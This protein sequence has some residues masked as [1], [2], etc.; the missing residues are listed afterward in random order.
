MR[1]LSVVLKRGRPIRPVVRIFLAASLVC[2]LGAVGVAPAFAAG[3]GSVPVTANF[4]LASNITLSSSANPALIGV[5]VTVTATVALISGNPASATGTVT[6]LDGGVSIGTG[7]LSGTDATWTGQLPE[8][9]HNLTATYGGDTLYTPGV[10]P[11]FVLP[12][13]HASAVVTTAFPGAAGN[14]LTTDGTTVDASVT[15]TSPT[16][17]VDLPSTRFTVSFPG[18]SGL[19]N[20]QMKLEQLLGG[21]WVDVPLGGSPLSGTFGDPAGVDLP[22][23]GTVTV[24]LRFTTQPGAPIGVLTMTS[25]LVG[26]LD[27]GVTFPNT[28]AIGTQ[29]VNVVRLPTVTTVAANSVLTNATSAQVPLTATVSPSIA[30][31]TVTFLDNGVVTGVGNVSGGVATYL[32]TV[33]LG[34]HAITATYSGDGS[35]Y[36][37]ST[38]LVPA[39]ITVTPA[40][41]AAHALPPIRILDTRNGIGARK[42][43]AVPANGRITLQVAGSGNLP[44]SNI[45][46]AILNMTIRTSSAGGYITLYASDQQASYVASLSF[47]AN[48]ITAGLTIV[49]VS[50]SGQVT[51]VNHSARPINLLGDSNGYFSNRLNSLTLGGRYA[52]LAPFRLLDN[53]KNGMKA[54]TSV[55][56]KMTGRSSGASKVPA[57]GVASVMLSVTGYHQNGDGFL[58]AYPAGLATI[59]DTS[60]LNWSKGI[61]RSNRVI[62]AVGTNGTVIF[63]NSFRSTVGLTI[64]IVGYFTSD[65]NPAGGTTY[66]PLVVAKRLM[67]GNWTANKAKYVTVSGLAGLP[68]TTAFQPPQGVIANIT[69]K[70]LTAATTLS[71]FPN[72]G[73]P[74]AVDLVVGKGRTVSNTAIAKIAGG[75]IIIYNKAGNTNV[76]IDVFGWFG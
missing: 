44:A 41:G 8:G 24:P 2:A 61:T 25:T 52:G 10:S 64:E 15:A 11:V 56:I 65:D 35:L 46:A 13:T 19:T 22:P 72:P 49:P 48:V 60:V 28:L 16:G 1:S 27:A 71:V 29:A 32:A 55:A 43:I 59:P 53:T 31:G 37:T 20:P 5:N 17:G 47:D 7:V 66:I 50:A 36:G 6:F 67:T 70:A 76:A 18:I 33:V 39:Q 40:G 23:G 30:A 54:G 9:S 3:G 62:V 14:N 73:N 63:K 69:A 4:K 42:G 38:T 51:I 34:A 57:T 58:T 74:P 21:S 45:E 75:R 12:V 68:R 26:S